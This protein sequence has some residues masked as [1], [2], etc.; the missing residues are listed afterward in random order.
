MKK[1]IEEDQLQQLLEEEMLKEAEAILA[2]V[3]S[4]DKLKEYSL[5]ESFDA[6][7]EQKI[8]QYEREQEQYANLS[9]EDKE[10]LRIGKEMQ[11]LKGLEE[12]DVEEDKPVQ[13]RKKKTLKARLLV[14][15]VAI[16][17]MGLGKT[18]MGDTPFITKFKKNKV[19]DREVTRVD[20][21]NDIEIT[22]EQIDEL[23]IYQQMEE[24]FGSQ[25]V[26][27]LYMPAQSKLSTAEIDDIF[28]K[29]IL[30]YECGKEFMEYTIYS[31][32]RN[33]SVGYDIEDELL[34][35]KK[36]IVDGNSIQIKKYIVE[37]EKAFRYVAQYKYKGLQ[38]VLVGVMQEQEFEKILNNLNFF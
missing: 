4:D 27:M 21:T 34:S 7:M 36:I 3:D 5:P 10:A 16:M 19:E 23:E 35:E 32:Y 18:A 2:E 15:L 28:K 30:R 9:E 14:A 22:N 20:T 8:L 38:Y 13:F 11:L 26:S 12:L 25:V 17:L 29:A 33:Q 37:Q 6:E 24:M 1:R 31:T